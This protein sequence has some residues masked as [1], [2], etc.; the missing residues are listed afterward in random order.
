M[1]PRHE[2]FQQ[3]AAVRVTV[4]LLRAAARSFFSLWRIPSL[5]NIDVDNPEELV[6]VALEDA[7]Q[8]AGGWLQ[9]SKPDKVSSAGAQHLDWQVCEHACAYAT[10]AGPLPKWQLSGTKEWPLLML[11]L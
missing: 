5:Q 3:A 11:A 10:G 9:N 6:K 2:R 1:S 4:H 7:R 8:M